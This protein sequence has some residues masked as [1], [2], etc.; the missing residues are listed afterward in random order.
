LLHALH[1]RRGQFLWA[2]ARL[3]AQMAMMSEQFEAL[4]LGLT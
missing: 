1:L 3:G 4:I 2:N